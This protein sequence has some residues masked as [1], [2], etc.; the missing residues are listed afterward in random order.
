[1]LKFFKKKEVLQIPYSEKEVLCNLIENYI[2]IANKNN[3]TLDDYISIIAFT[4]LLQIQ[5]KEYAKD[6]Q[7]YINKFEKQ[8]ILDEYQ[9]YFKSVPKR[10]FIENHFQANMDLASEMLYGWFDGCTNRPMHYMIIF[11]LC[12]K[13]LTNKQ[14][15]IMAQ[16]FEANWEIFSMQKE[17]YTKLYLNSGIYTNNYFLSKKDEEDYVKTQY[18]MKYKNL[19]KVSNNK[20]DYEKYMLK[21]LSYTKKGD[22]D[23]ARFYIREK[24][25]DEAKGQIDK[26]IKDRKKFA[27]ED[28]YDYCLEKD[29]YT[30]QLVD[31]YELK[32]KY[33]YIRREIIEMFDIDVKTFNNLTKDIKDNI[34]YKKDSNYSQKIISYLKEKI[35]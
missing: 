18:Y 17:Y 10:I 28:G 11:G 23:L 7:F 24:R 22:T 31:F 27:K 12:G 33:P 26:I 34:E 5:Y 20:N 3:T 35:N 15:Y 30:K 25:F 2:I 16:I 1:M 8:G 9:T 32:V 4:K 14:K 13:P 21:A 6:L 19:A 29:T